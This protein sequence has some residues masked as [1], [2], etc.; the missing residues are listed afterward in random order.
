MSRQFDPE[1]RELMDTA[2][3]LDAEFE[4]DL[5]NLISLNRRFGS[6]RLVRHFLARWLN[7]GRCYRVLDLCTGAGDLPRVMVS[8]ARARNIT[9]RIDAID[10]NASALELARRRSADFSEIRYEQA[11]ALQFESNER[12]DLVHSSLA[13]H[14]FSD[15]DAVRLLSKCRELSNRW[16]LVADLERSPATTIGVWL[17]T[18][19]IYRDPMTVYD[20]R[21]SARRAFS[22]AE[23][24]AL[25]KSAGWRDFGQAR[26]LFCRQAIWQESREF[27]DVPIQTAELPTLA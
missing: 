12:Y 3:S 1:Q 27:G 2:A 9:L 23:L 20:G 8:W 19:L 21:L 26:F 14:H 17:L 10:A 4:H 18:A 11:D 16:T 6:H 22:F 24:R 13:L 25:A 15:I 5:D 7:P